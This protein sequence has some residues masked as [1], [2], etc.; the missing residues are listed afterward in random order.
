MNGHT[1]KIPNAINFLIKEQIVLFIIFLNASIFIILDVNPDI[2]YSYPWLEYVDIV[3]ILYFI[4]EA[5]LKI[6]TLGFKNYINDNWNKFDLIIVISSVPILLEPLIPSLASNLSWTPILRMTRILR[7]AKFLRL[8]RLVRYAGRDGALSEFRI[9]IYF[10]LFIVTANFIFSLVSLP[11]HIDEF[12]SI[13]YAPL[14]ILSSV[15]IISKLSLLIQNVYINPIVESEYKESAEA[16]MD[17][18]RTAYVILL[19][20]IG[21]IVSIEV[22]GFNSFSLIAGLGIGSVAIA[23]AAQDALGNIIAGIS[24]FA[25]KH[26]K[27]GDYLKVGD[28][29]GRV[30]NLGLR[31]FILER[32]DGSR[33]SIPNRTINTLAIE[34]LSVRNKIKDSIYIQ[35]SAALSS[36]ELKSSL[37]II[38]KT[39]ANFKLISNFRIKIVEMRFTHNIN[40]TFISNIAEAKKELGD[41]SILDLAPKIS[42]RLYLHIFENLE[43]SDLTPENKILFMQNV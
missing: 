38:K 18:G 40:I 7:L 17:F 42:S 10:I 1:R 32:R 11:T 8:G 12:I 23:F 37:D 33:V 39:C 4:F 19:W 43:K 3:C 34:N 29:E 31:S 2:S 6:Y 36:D 22:A 21:L 20:S 24:L 41:M 15:A 28:N 27:V 35:L 14:L 16:I 5:F 26:F 13:I 9:P 25:Q 30:V